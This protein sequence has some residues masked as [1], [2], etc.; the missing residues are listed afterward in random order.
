LLSV[1]IIVF[2]GRDLLLAWYA[3]AASMAI[4][5]AT[6]ESLAAHLGSRFWVIVFLVFPCTTAM[7]LSPLFCAASV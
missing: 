5:S 3:N 4:S 1:A 2:I 7:P 6:V